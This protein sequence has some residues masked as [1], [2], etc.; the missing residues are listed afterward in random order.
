MKIA[1]QNIMVNFQRVLI[2]E[3]VGHWWNERLV[4]NAFEKLYESTRVGTGPR[5]KTFLK[6][7]LRNYKKSK[8]G[9]GGLL[10]EAFGLACYVT[11]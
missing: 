1:S 6:I 7:Y 9:G 2:A 4:S 8:F 11:V 3:T 10:V 5:V